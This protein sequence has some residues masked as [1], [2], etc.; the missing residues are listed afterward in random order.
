MKATHSIKKNGVWHPAGTEVPE[1]AD[2]VVDGKAIGKVDGDV[3]EITDEEVIEETL[4]EMH[5][6][7]KS[8]TKTEINR[9]S[10]AEL[11]ALANEQGITGADE[12]TGGDLKKILI[13]KFGL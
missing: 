6:E 3:I 7:S 8:Y 9:L 11:K 5:S 13:D 1:D 12:M 4:K 10:T 2:F